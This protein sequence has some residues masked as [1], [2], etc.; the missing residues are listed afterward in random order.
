[1]RYLVLP[2]ENTPQSVTSTAKITQ[3]ACIEL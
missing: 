2:V 1:M 3:L